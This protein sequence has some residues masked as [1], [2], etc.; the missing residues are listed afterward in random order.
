MIN[1]IWTCPLY[2]D[3]VDISC[4]FL[5]YAMGAWKIIDLIKLTP[6]LVAFVADRLSK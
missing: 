1:L 5:L 3:W 2:F 6:K 4:Q